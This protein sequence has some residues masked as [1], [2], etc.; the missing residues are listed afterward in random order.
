MRLF[1]AVPVPEELRAKAAELGKEMKVDKR[2]LSFVKAGNMHL[3]LRFLGE[4]DDETVAEVR[5]RLRTIKFERFE[6][7]LRGIGAFPNENYVRIVW[8]GAE[9]GGK[10]EA[11][12]KNVIHVLRGFGKEEKEEGGQFSAHLTLAR[13]KQRVDVREFIAKHKNDQFGSFEISEFHLIA[14]VLKPEGSEYKVVE[15]FRA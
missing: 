3:T 2:A 15:K 13:V 11:L 12:A 7:A 4:I 8:V 14:S 5:E 10:L 1:V 6:C 9:S